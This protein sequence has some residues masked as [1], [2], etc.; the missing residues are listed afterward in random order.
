MFKFFKKRPKNRWVE[1]EIKLALEAERSSDPSG[2]KYSESI[3]RS[4]RK[5]YYPLLAEGPSELSLSITLNILNK[6]AKG[7]PLTP[8]TEKDFEGI[9]PLDWQKWF[10]DK[11][12][13]KEIYQC[14]RYSALFK[15]VG[16]DGKISYSDNN[17]VLTVD[18]NG[19]TC[20]GGRA[21][22]LIN[23]MYPIVLPYKPGKSYKVYTAEFTYDSSS[24]E[25]TIEPG[26]YNAIYT[27]YVTTPEGGT[28]TI[29]EFYF[30]GDGCKFKD[31]GNLKLKLKEAL[32]EHGLSSKVI[33][34]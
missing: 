3:Y 32:E 29:D 7:M 31:F 34:F 30:E 9:K 21:S 15:H 19:F 25:V 16:N 1:N 6:L 2:I 13:L 26:I 22:E 18:R 23:S 33:R 17:R 12:G 14:P 27:G 5:A 20:Y 4:V 10:L 28:I 24:G 11:K 8:I